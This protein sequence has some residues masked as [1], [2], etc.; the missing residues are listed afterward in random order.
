MSNS[1]NAESVTNE[2]SGLNPFYLYFHE[3]KNKISSFSFKTPIIFSGL[4]L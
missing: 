4:S 2:F 3:I 1:L